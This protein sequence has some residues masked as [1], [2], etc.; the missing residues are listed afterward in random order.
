MGVEVVWTRLG[1]IGK[2][3]SVGG[4]FLRYMYVMVKNHIP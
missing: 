1:K 2:Y 4:G 3:Y